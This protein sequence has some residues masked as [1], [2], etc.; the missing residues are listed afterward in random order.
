MCGLIITFRQ[1]WP[2][3]TFS[4]M[5]MAHS[6]SVY[7]ITHVGHTDWICPKCEHEKKKYLKKKR[8]RVVCSGPVE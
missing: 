4:N 2:Y 7:T 5:T 8:E 3:S 6:I 1:S